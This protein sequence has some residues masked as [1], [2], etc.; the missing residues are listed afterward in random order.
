VN[1]DLAETVAAL[2]D[3]VLRAMAEAAD[4]SPE[5]KFPVQG[6]QLTFHVAVK[7][8]AGAEG[9]VR[10]WVIEAGGSGTLSNEEIHE[11]TV[12]LGAPV[13]RSGI[14]VAVSQQQDE[15]P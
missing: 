14:G 7:K 9:K 2:R 12:A 8:E 3:E 4:A 11:V 10:F 15:R 6:V 1:L 5:I 13:N